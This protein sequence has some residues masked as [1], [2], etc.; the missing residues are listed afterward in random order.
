MA[1]QTFVVLTTAGPFEKYGAPVVEACAEL[2]TNYCD[3]T[4]EIHVSMLCVCAICMCVCMYGPFEKYGAPV[5]EACAELGT[6][7]CDITGEIHV[8]MCGFNV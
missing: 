6:N 7:Y 8:S 4:G 5:V 3:I 1:S 2:G